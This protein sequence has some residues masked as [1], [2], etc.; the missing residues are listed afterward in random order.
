M[1][2]NELITQESIALWPLNFEN[3]WETFCRHVEYKWYPGGLH[4]LWRKAMEN[5]GEVQ[6]WTF[7]E[8]PYQFTKIAIF[9]LENKVMNTNLAGCPSSTSH[10]IGSTCSV[11]GMKD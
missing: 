10:H 11:C 2:T 6:V 3:W 9:D 1:P 5:P 4:W 8:G 7:K